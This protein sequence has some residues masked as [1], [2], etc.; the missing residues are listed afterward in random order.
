MSFTVTCDECGS[1]NVTISPV[2]NG[3]FIELDFVCDDCGHT[4]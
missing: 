4:S 2:D 1:M 3:E